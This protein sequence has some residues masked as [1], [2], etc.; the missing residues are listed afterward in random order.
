VQKRL[1]RKWLALAVCVA[2]AAGLLVVFWTRSGGNRRPNA[3]H[4]E[5]VSVPAANDVST[6]ELPTLQA[7]RLAL[8]ES[9]EAMVALMEHSASH[10][11]AAITPCFRSGAQEWPN[12]SDR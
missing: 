12:G 11:F 8:R 1:H 10:R 3:L 5:T 9:P 6:D 7:C 4:K 2:A